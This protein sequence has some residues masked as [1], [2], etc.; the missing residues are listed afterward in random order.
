VNIVRK[1]SFFVTAVHCNRGDRWAIARKHTRTFGA[2]AIAQNK[3][4][5]RNGDRGFAVAW[6]GGSRGRKGGLGCGGQE[7]RRMWNLSPAYIVDHLRKKCG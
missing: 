4:E 7:G 6:A 2:G 5:V 1:A 3:K